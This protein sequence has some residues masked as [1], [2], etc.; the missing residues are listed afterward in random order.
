VE[1]AQPEI[2]KEVEREYERSLVLPSH[3]PASQWMLMPVGLIGSGKTT[4]VTT[5]A[6][7][8]GLIRLST[9]EVRKL[10]KERGYGFKGCRDIVAEL[11]RKYL[12]LG[13]GIALDANTGSE[14]GLIY[15]AKTKELY[16]EVRQIFIHIDPPETFILG[17][18]GNRPQK[19]WL[20]ESG[21]HAI[22]RY[23]ENKARFTLPD[24]PFV[25][26]FDPS[27]KDFPLQLEQGIKAINKT[28]D[29]SS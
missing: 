26:T 22:E 6:E 10:L 18:L 5:L 16:P 11:A 23:F 8:F 1:N 13:Y 4:I 15:N 2:L 29:T 21:E 17:H 20:F 19:S 27:Q 3:K 25:Y 28:L 9:D 14:Q 7:H 12:A 24:L